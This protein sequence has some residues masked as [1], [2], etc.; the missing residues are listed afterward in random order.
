MPKTTLE[1]KAFIL[2]TLWMDYRD[3]EDFQDFFQYNDLGLPLAYLITSGIV[4]RTELADR[5]IE[6]TFDLL[7]ARLEVEDTGFDDL[8]QI[9]ML[10]DD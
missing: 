9:L 3:A 4:M 2:S 6:D 1:N 8:G 10:D 7:L 5:F